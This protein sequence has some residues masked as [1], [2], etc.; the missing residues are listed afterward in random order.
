MI[1]LNQS[2]V[3]RIAPLP[4][5]KARLVVSSGGPVRFNFTT[6]IFAGTGVKKYS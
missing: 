3:V 2:A 1:V 5:F 4:R 6:L